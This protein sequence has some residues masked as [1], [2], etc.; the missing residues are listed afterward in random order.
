M[1]GREECKTWRCRLDLYRPEKNIVTVRVTS[2]TDR[3]LKGYMGVSQ[4]VGL[5]EFSSTI[6]LLLLAEKLMDDMSGP[7]RTEARRSFGG[8]TAAPEPVKAPAECRHKAMATFQIHIMFRQN[9]TWQ[10]R[11][12]W[13]DEAREARFRS[14]LELINLIHSALTAEDEA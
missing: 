14:A 9:A 2:Y 10:G 3:C 12:I 11:L 8:W 5:T 4:E 7:Q 1:S 13:V 6:D